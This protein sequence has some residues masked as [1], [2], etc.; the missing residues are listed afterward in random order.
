[1]KFGTTLS[2]LLLF[3]LLGR[4]QWS[5]TT[6]Q[7]YD[8]L[9]TNVSATTGDQKQPIVVKSYP[10]SGYFVI[11]VDYRDQATGNGS[12]IYAQKFDKAGKALWTANGVAVV[13]GKGYQTFAPPSNADYRYYS[14]ACTDSAGGFYIAWDDDN[15][16]AGSTVAHRV[17]VQHMKS[18]GSAVFLFPGYIVASPAA[19]LSYQYADP[20]LIA[21]GNKGFF[22]GYIKFGSYNDMYV[23]CLRDEGGTMVNYG[24]GQMDVNGIN[25]PTP[26][27][28]GLGNNINDLDARVTGFSIYPDLQ[29]GC[30][31]VMT[32]DWNTGGNERVFTGY[33]KLCRV[34]KESHVTVLKRTSNIAVG[35]TLSY[36][37]K[38]DSVVRL[39]NY[40]T[41][42]N[43]VS[44]KDING[45]LYVQTDYYVENGG[46]GYANISGLVYNTEYAKGVMIPTDGNIN[47]NLVATSQRNLNAGNSTVGYWY[48]LLYSFADEVYDSIPYQL[49]SDLTDPYYAYRPTPEGKVLDK[50][51]FGGDTILAEST[52]D[53]DFALAGTG[54]RIFASGMMYDFPTF[55]NRYC[56]LQQLQV[57]RISP[58]S[59][60]IHYQTPGKTGLTIGSEL[61]TGFSGSEIHYDNPL[62]TTDLHGNALF[63]INEVGYSARVSPIGDSAKLLWGPMGKRIGTGVYGG[64]YYSPVNPFVA[65]SPDDGTAVIAWDDSRNNN[66]TV[67]DY[68]DILMRHLDSLKIY[69]YAPPVRALKTLSYAGSALS[70]GILYGTTGKW[71]E[72]DGFNSTT[73]ESTPVLSLSD[74]YNLGT[75]TGGAYDYLQSPAR[76]ST[77]GKPY[78]SRDWLITPQNNPAG[79]A[80]I[81]VRLYFTTAQFVQ[82]QTADPSI[83]S[84][85]DLIVVKQPAAGTNAPTEYTPATGDE[86]IVPTAWAAVDGGYYAE[87]PVSSFSQ[88]FIKKNDGVLPVTWLSVR[89][90][91]GANS[92]ATVTWSVTNE[93]NIKNYTVQYSEDGTTYK[94]GCT[95]TPSNRG[96]YSCALPADAAKVYYFRVRDTDLTGRWSNSIIVRLD[97]EVGGVHFTLS[98]NPA[99]H[100]ATL[101]YTLPA[102]GAATLTLTNGAGATLWQQRQTLG[103]SGTVKIP[104]RNLPAGIY[105]LRITTDRVS[106]TIRLEKGA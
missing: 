88:F 103:T 57:D 93:V 13:A 8:S 74:N 45:N 70:P 58:T 89:A 106:E 9:H 68:E 79:A 5:N 77:D 50:L 15:P 69:D 7:F 94:D 105:Y 62:I 87:L 38:K 37:Y 97:K 84:P 66:S 67:T 17:A 104:V 80:A 61:A 86:F 92:T 85:G 65:M 26:K 27:T 56:K 81:G 11:W 35:D 18:D 1:M 51:D 102:A 6:N 76:T 91:R 83:A 73:F 47:L 31:V 49:A 100:E 32:M 44:C 3:S 12:D 82:L 25:V 90:A 71:T 95:V 78:L 28:C 43:T 75:I 101:S 41:F 63:S 10:D 42:F 20:Q 60:A 36:T 16:D 33:N 55:S 29:G 40:K 21:D 24:G 2:F 22:I 48:K 34:K 4:A 46:N 99:H 64:H 72:F 14:Y 54:N 96:A 39:Y 53:Y 23:Q 19:D 52:Y 30:G 98:P 59:F